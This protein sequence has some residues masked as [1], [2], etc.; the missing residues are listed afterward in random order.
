M[1]KIVINNVGYVFGEKTYKMNKDLNFKVKL[2]RFIKDDKIVVL[3]TQK[4]S[5]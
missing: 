5:H 1:D 4:F 3:T 2:V